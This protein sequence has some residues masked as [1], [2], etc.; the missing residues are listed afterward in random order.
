MDGNGRWARKRGLPRLMGH[1]AGTEN[2]RRIVRGCVENGV[3]Y[4]TL[5]AFSTENWNRPSSEVQGL[6]RILAEVIE[7]ETPELNREGV[8]ICH[9]GHMEGVPQSL[10][11]AINYAL[12]TTKNNSRLILS[13]CFN[14]GGRDD[15]VRA[16][17]KLI[18]E[19]ARP[20]DITEEAISQHLDTNG[21]PD[22]DLIVR[23]AGE[24]RLSNFL[25]WQAAYAEYY[26]T[27]TC[28]P[29]FDKDSLYEALVA[30][31]LRKRKFGGILPEEHVEYANGNAEDP[32]NGVGEASPT[33]NSAA[34]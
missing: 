18:A 31:S 9:F 32:V 10:Q 23:T 4:L 5:Y 28:W 2:I 14:Y 13:V 22:P 27:P 15:I 24:M 7:R 11:D 6:L 17:R 1:R 8:R 3:K 29:D 25:I 30:Y 26:S 21:T 19:G 12:D 34:V 20:E 16:M 33:T